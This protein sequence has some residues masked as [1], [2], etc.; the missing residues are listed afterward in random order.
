MSKKRVVSQEEVV[1]QQSVISTD[2]A[3]L[4]T[5]PV[6]HIR[7][8][9]MR[10]DELHAMRQAIPNFT[11]PASPDATRRLNT[12]ASLPPEFVETAALAMHNSEA[13]ARVGGVDSSAIRDWMSFAEAY[14]GVA[15]VNEANAQFI[16][17]SIA[18]ARNRAGT[19]ALTIYELA[20]RLAKRP[21]TAELAPYVADMRRALAPR[22][23]KKTAKPT[24]PPP[25]KTEPNKK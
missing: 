17:H 13:L 12:V 1:S 16:R 8:A 9:Q 6:N 5:E 11:I 2:V 23:R 3:A 19:E 7:E 10:V 4:T 18:A 14:G 24:T 15:D 20:K 25:V 21:E 22:F